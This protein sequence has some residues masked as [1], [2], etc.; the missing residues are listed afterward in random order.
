MKRLQSEFPPALRSLAAKDK[1][2]EPG[3]IIKLEIRRS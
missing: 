2:D 1:L 3:K